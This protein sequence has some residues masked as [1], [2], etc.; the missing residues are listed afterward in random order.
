MRKIY[1]KLVVL[2]LLTTS[3]NYLYAQVPQGINFQAIARDTD[4]QPM[5]NTNIQIQLSILDDEQGN[6][7]VYQELRSLMTNDYGSFSFQIGVDANYVTIGSFDE[8]DWASGPKSLQIDYDPTNTFTFDLTLGTIQFATV[9]YAFVAQDV[10]YIDITGVQDGDILIYNIDTGKFEPG[11]MAASSVN[12]ENILEVPNF[13][14]VATSGDYNDL[15]NIP[16][17]PTDLSDLSDNNELLFS[18]DYNDLTNKPMEI[19]PKLVASGRK[20]TVSFSGGDV[21]TFSQASNS[22]PSI[23]A[24]ASLRLHQGTSTI[25]ALD[26]FFVNNKRFDVI[27]D[28]PW[29]IPSGIYDIILGPGTP[30]EQTINSSFKVK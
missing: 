19:Y 17:I 3:I 28:I 15:S 1:T 9:P 4:S 7:I 30:C 14:E 8:I 2:L 26:T 22:C 20:V 11:Q 25:N 16:V 13:A 29:Y 21:V 27:F 23:W 24:S 6:A 18:G 10:V 12:W 5:A